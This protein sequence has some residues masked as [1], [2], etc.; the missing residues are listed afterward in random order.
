MYQTESLVC[1]C[2]LVLHQTKLSEYFSAALRHRRHSL[3]VR[4][5]L[6]HQ[7][8]PRTQPKCDVKNSN[9]STT[10]PS[11]FSVALLVRRRRRR[12]ASRFS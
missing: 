10:S 2:L 1:V 4:L 8:V 3:E 11:L 6:S 7:A 9:I 5:A 12:R